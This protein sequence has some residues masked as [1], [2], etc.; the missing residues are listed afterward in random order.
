MANLDAIRNATVFEGIDEPHLR[1]LG[2]IA[3][4]QETRQG[5]RL[6]ARGETAETFYVA[7]RGRFALALPV[8]VFDAHDEIVVEEK[9]A[10]DA[11]GWSSLVEPWIS[12]YSAY[13]IADGAVVRFPGEALRRLIASDDAMGSRFSANLNVLIGARVRAAQDLW[14]AELE[15]SRARVDYWARSEMTTRLHE[16]VSPAEGPRGSFVSALERL[17]RIGNPSVRP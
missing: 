16:A 8:R 17:I 12:I 6:F 7:K 3:G 2:E 5:E 4:E 10:W 14:I 1:Q 11:F 15:Q 13:C 9:Q